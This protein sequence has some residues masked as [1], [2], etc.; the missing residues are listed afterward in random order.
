MGV[1]SW[2]NFD[3]MPKILDFYDQNQFENSLFRSK[4]PSPILPLPEIVEGITFATKIL[5]QDASCVNQRGLLSY[6]KLYE[7]VQHCRKMLSREKKPPI[8]QIIETGLVPHLSELLL[9]D[10]TII[11]LQ[12]T[13]NFVHPES[14]EI[15][16]NTIFEA[17]WALTNICSGTSQQTHAVVYANALPKF[18]RLLKMTTHMNIVEQAA[19]AL[20]NIAGDGPELRDQVLENNV[21]EPLLHLLTI[22]NASVPFLQNTTWTLSNLCRNKDPPTDLK[23]VKQLLPGL[24][25]LMSHKDRQIKTDAGWAIFGGGVKF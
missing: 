24:V 10:E 17:A 9:L 11:A 16:Y 19:W 25:S 13:P 8:D 12:N 6:P 3:K 18:I 7:C 14:E 15:V 23:Y 1:A 2:G 22:E 4:G 5:S 21:L 20:G